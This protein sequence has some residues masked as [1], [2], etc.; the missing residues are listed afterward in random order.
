MV[1]GAKSKKNTDKDGSPASPLA[2]LLDNSKVELVNNRI[3][4]YAGISDDNILSFNKHLQSLVVKAKV[5]AATNELPVQQSGSAFVHIQSFGGSVFSGLS[6]MDTI[7]EAKESIPVTT[8][9]DGCAASAATFLSIVG[10]RRLM[11]RNSYMLIHQLSSGVWGKYDS[12]KD[13]VE[14]LDLFMKTITD[15]Y[16][17]YTKVPPSKIK[18]ILKR[19][20]WW[21]AKTCLK[22]GMIDEII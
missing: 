10:T 21:D 9:V 6:G 18:Q 20:M 17:E 19:D 3:Y 2:G 13:E 16:E 7:L 12:I 11:R 4:Y 15:M 1:W 22:Y 5:H 14:N 8:L